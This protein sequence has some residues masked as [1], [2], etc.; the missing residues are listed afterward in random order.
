MAG[1]VELPA[2]TL[3][4]P[5]WRYRAEHARVAHAV[6]DERPESPTLCGTSNPWS[7][8]TPWLGDADEVER[9]LVAGMRRCGRC[10]R[11]V[12][13]AQEGPSTSGYATNGTG[14]EMAQR[15]SLNGAN[16]F[17]LAGIAWG[18]P[19][20]EAGVDDPDIALMFLRGQWGAGTTDTEI[21]VA[22]TANML[23]VVHRSAEKTLAVLR[24]IPVP[25]APHLAEW[26]RPVTVDVEL[27]DTDTPTEA[28]PTDA[29]SQ[30]PDRDT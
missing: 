30:T 26:E 25:V 20:D 3:Q 6:R 22:M 15:T 16:C 4:R 19:A 29:P 18:C 10:L 5:L 17:Y 24:E 2:N 11:I 21:V 7:R 12:A 13:A 23:S 9:A 8:P 1:M 27:P 28:S 14:Q